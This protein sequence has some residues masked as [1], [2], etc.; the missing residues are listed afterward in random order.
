MICLNYVRD[1]KQLARLIASCDAFVH[2]NDQEPF[3]LIV[4]EAMAAGLPVVGPSTGG[5]SELIDEEVGQPA[6]EATAAGMAEAIDAL[7]QRDLAALSLAAR[8]RAEERH[9]WDR[10]FQGLMD[11]Y[12]RLLGA[13]VAQPGR[14]L[15]A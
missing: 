4:L 15:D 12:G 8:R 6:R 13:P 9:T 5:V 3:G 10:T 7:F 11:A 1:S 2:A 14:R